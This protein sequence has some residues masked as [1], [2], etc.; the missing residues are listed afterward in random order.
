VRPVRCVRLN[1]W[2]KCTTFEV[3][4]G[5]AALRGPLKDCMR[6]LSIPYKKLKKDAN[7]RK[8]VPPG[9]RPAATLQLSQYF[10]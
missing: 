6:R 4:R 3:L 5:D 7:I 8:S 9:D 2:L 10:N 1:N